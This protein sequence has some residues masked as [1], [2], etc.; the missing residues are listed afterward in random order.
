MCRRDR[1]ASSLRAVYARKENDEN[2]GA[3][4]RHARTRKGEGHER[5][6]QREKALN[7]AKKFAARESQRR[8]SPQARLTRNQAAYSAGKNNNVR[9]VATSRPPM[10][11]T[12]SG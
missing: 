1:L 11:A 3:R 12:A 5:R 9:T 8:R 6:A 2:D 4:Q 7:V 10:I